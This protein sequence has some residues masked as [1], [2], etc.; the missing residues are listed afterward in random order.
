MKTWLT[1]LVGA[2]VGPMVGFL[3]VQFVYTSSPNW[4]ILLYPVMWLSDI[5]A[6][7]FMPHDDYGGLVTFLPALVLYCA[8]IGVLVA[9]ICR[10]CWRRFSS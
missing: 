9:L 10:Y 1:I 6:D 8:G 3:L 2:V 7:I 4:P 5:L